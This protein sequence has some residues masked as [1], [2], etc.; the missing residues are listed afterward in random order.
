M[1]I[2]EITIQYSKKKPYPSQT[3][4]FNLCPTYTKLQGHIDMSGWATHHSREN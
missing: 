3:E 1:H 2:S 4:F